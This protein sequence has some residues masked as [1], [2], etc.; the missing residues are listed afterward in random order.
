MVTPRKGVYLALCLGNLMLRFIWTISVFGGVPGHGAGMLFFELIEILRRTVWAV[1]RIEWE[2]IVKVYNASYDTLALKKMLERHDVGSFLPS[3]EV[4]DPLRDPHSGVALGLPFDGVV[5][6]RPTGRPTGEGRAPIPGRRLSN[7][8]GQVYIASYDNMALKHI[9]NSPS[10]SPMRLAASEPDAPGRL[11]EFRLDGVEEESAAKPPPPVES[12]R[13]SRIE[14]RR[15]R[16]G[17]SPRRAPNIAITPLA[18]SP[19]GRNSRRGSQPRESGTPPEISLPP[20]LEPY[21]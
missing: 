12:H 5:M 6:G 7:D 18:P 19:L 1:F 3:E 17:G 8:G 10:F 11:E 9:R 4:S 14:L 15:L 20:S 21:F 13:R 2:V 16:S